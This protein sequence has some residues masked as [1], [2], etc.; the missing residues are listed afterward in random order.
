MTR[1]PVRG[2]AATGFRAP[3]EIA[4]LPAPPAFPGSPLGLARRRW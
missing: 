2:P 4:G 3:L 1:L